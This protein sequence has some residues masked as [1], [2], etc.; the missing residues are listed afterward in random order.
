MLSTSKIVDQQ[1]HAYYH[2]SIEINSV[3]QVDIKNP[4][5]YFPDDIISIKNLNPNKIRID[6][7]FEE[8]LEKNIWH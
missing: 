2:I 1:L 7:Y 5:Y 6:E 8:K 3:E 4:T